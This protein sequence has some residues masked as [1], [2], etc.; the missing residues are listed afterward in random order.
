MPPPEGFVPFLAQQ[1]T[2][3]TIA[4]DRIQP[5]PAPEDLSQY[6]LI[7][8]QA[9][10][11]RPMDQNCDGPSGVTEMRI[12]FDCLAKRYLDARTLARAVKAALNGFKGA[13]PDGSYIE[14]V[15]TGMVDRF[16]D[17]SRIYC[18]SVHALVRYR[19]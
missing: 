2:I 8:Y 12:V 19:D 9:V 5:I 17:G 15:Q 16:E 3:S 6:P 1:F 7:T 11:D 4:G 10:S 18:T 14:D 13:L